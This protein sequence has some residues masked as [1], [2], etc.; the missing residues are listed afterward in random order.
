MCTPGVRMMIKA[1]I[2]L[3][4]TV[5]ATLTLASAAASAYQGALAILSYLS[6][7]RRS[8]L[9][10]E[11]A[12]QSVLVLIPA[13]NEETTIGP[14]LDDVEA[15]E[16]QGRRPRIVVIADNCTD[17]TA[18]VVAA[19]GMEV[20]VREDPENRGKG[21]ALAWALKHHDLLDETDV[22]F[23]LDADDRP[24]AHALDAALA[25]RARIGAS[26]VQVAHISGGIDES[27]A[28]AIDRWAT[29]LINRVRPRGLSLLGLPTRLQG[30][31]M[32]FDADVLR[33]LG[34]PTGGIS[35]DMFASLVFLDEGYHI[36]FTDNAVVWALSERGEEARRSQ[37]LRW[38]SGR[39]LAVWE[40][41]RL[42]RTALTRPSGG[43]A[44]MAAHVLVPPLTVH[45]ASL[46]FEL[47]IAGR[48]P[49]LRR[50]VLAGGLATAVYLAEGL[51]L[52]GRRD[53]A[54]RAVAAGLRFGWWKLKIQVEALRRFRT[55]RWEAHSE[56]EAHARG[57]EPS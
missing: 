2:K 44:V 4:R 34:W 51:R 52:L 3:I 57:G 12:E 14:C 40:V 30:G 39:L 19:R 16:S 22:V 6:S 35:E 11:P 37:R 21:E 53:L 43:H 42:V 27:P 36:G 8:P 7:D 1:A 46:G 24:E 23:M 25:E 41:P 28:S 55:V 13:H 33:A 47:V 54:N 20:L 29:T 56:D 10:P 48:R 26:I 31:G 15:L 50:L 18:R 17:D 5:V 45:V 49:W 38:E 32:L 9:S